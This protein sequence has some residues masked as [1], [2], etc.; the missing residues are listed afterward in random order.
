MKGR[1]RTARDARAGLGGRLRGRR[2]LAG[3]ASALALCALAGCG[4]GPGKAPSAV[5][6]LV[7]RDFGASTLRSS[8]APQVK[9]EETVMRL[10]QRNASVATRYG[11]GFVQS[12]DGLAGGSEGGEPVDWF[13]YVN[14]VQ[15]PKGAAATTV[16]PGDHIW[17]DRH[18]WSQTEEVPAVVGSFPE[19]FLNG[20][21]GKR[22]PVSVECA[23]P[24]ATPC[25]T[26]IDRLRAAG[27][28]AAVSGLGSEIGA[29]Q[30]LRIAVAPFRALARD[31]GVLKLARGPRSS[32]VYA[33]FEG[34]DETL[35]LLD[36]G[37]RAVQ[38]LGAGAGLI[39]ATRTG[40]E[41]PV[42]A[43]TG[44]D[45]VGVAH[46]AREFDAATLHARFALAVGPSGEALALPRPGAS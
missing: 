36:E 8:G 20:I 14:G 10:L 39:A 27:V 9:G 33:R 28:P 30:T 22:L 35:A 29:L 11:G 37:G 34:G 19:P 40:E 41:A 25:R 32:G 2:A 17:W 13:Y 24:H 23:S 6:L 42:W 18:D 16:H 1:P 31:P 5:Q 15:A 26:V 43:V 4:L 3:A 44:T 7:T 45:E 46:A 21:E 38:R 12:I